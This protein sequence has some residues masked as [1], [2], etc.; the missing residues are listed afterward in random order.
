MAWLDDAC[1]VFSGSAKAQKAVPAIDKQPGFRA[2]IADLEP[3]A[4]AVTPP[5]RENYTNV[6]ASV[7]SPQSPTH[8]GLWRQGCVSVSGTR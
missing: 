5:N 6:C 1:E 2:L 3:Q 4:A 8:R 7:T